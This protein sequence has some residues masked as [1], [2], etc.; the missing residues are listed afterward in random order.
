M[1]RM[2]FNLQYRPVATAHTRV[3]FHMV[4]LVFTY[5]VSEEQIHVWFRPTATR[6]SQ[7]GYKYD[8]T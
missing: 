4:P 6:G 3:T 8:H 1:Y 2:T 5:S 7:R